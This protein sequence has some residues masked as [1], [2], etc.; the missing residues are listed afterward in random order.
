MS[1]V[2]VGIATFKRPKML[3]LLL[4]ALGK[5]ET[6]ADI[7]V[8]VADNDAAAREGVAVVDE[9]RSS[10]FPFPLE[11]TVVETRGISYSRNAILDHAFSDAATDFVAMI[12]D[13]QWPEP[14]WLEEMLKMQ[15][16]TG[17]DVVGAAVWPEFE[18]SPPQWAVDSKVYALDTTSNG[19]VDVVLGNG[20]VLIARNFTKL[21]PPPWYDHAFAR[22][23][24]EDGDLFMRLH[25]VGGRFARASHAIVHET[26]PASRM[27]L[28][29][30]LARAFRTGNSEMRRVILRSWSRGYFL[31]ESA[32]IVAAFVLVPFAF[33]LFLWSPGRRVDS[34][35]ILWRAAGKV[36]ALQGS[37]HDE[38]ATIHGR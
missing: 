36:A 18:V 8:L 25:A 14:R 24:G 19:R 37:T 35:C 10:G 7:R 33:L 6:H 30:A 31:K 27:T 11:S 29:W 32:K 16:D 28:R 9:L 21:L 12:D 5:T 26:I 20:G 17:A 34:L 23:G 2:L 1:H 4:L 13:D 38:Y 15:Q 22:T 3:R